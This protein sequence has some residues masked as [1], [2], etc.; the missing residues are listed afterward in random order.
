MKKQFLII[1]L[2]VGLFLVVSGGVAAAAY[3]DFN[4]GTK[5]TITDITVFKNEKL[6]RGTG[7]I[8]IWRGVV[9][10]GDNYQDPSG[11][12]TLGGYFPTLYIQQVSPNAPYG[13]VNDAIVLL[14][15]GGRYVDNNNNPLSSISVIR[16]HGS[17]SEPRE[18]ELRFDNGAYDPDVLPA[19][20][21]LYMQAA[22]YTW[23]SDGI[24]R[25]KPGLGVQMESNQ[26]EVRIKYD[27]GDIAARIAA[28]ASKKASIEFVNASTDTFRDD[29][30][31]VTTASIYR[32]ADSNE[33]RIAVA[34]DYDELQDRM[35]INS[36]GNV[37]IGTST[38]SYPLD[39]VT[40]GE[41]R[42]LNVKSTINTVE[43]LNNFAA[44][45]QMIPADTAL[46]GGIF[47]AFSGNV[48]LH[49]GGTVTKLQ[50][51]VN[52]I[53][54]NSSTISTIDTAVGSKVEL[55]R[56]TGNTAD[57]T[58]T[59]YYGFHSYGN[60]GQGSGN[61]GGTDWRHAYFEDFPD[62]GGTIANVAGLWIDQQTSGTN[63]YGIV[64]NGDGDGADIVFG[65]NQEASIYSA[66]GELWVMDGAGNDTQISPH[67]PKTGEWI[68]YS[69]NVKTGRVLRVNMEELVRD[70]EK[71]TGKKYLIET[72]IESK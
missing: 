68:F 18:S 51:A 32:P 61:I 65:P 67:D 47:T 64:L 7:M 69:K 16:N 14:V 3:I 53:S 60:A 39:V 59:D 62:F 6:F 34:D 1:G 4:D 35:V 41:S 22:I 45:Y 70:M 9:S 71:L 11:Y 63:N 21:Y 49:G 12:D 17:I 44:Y 54:L 8:K 28:E 30:L 26:G 19:D 50:G 25:L 72:F 29:S 58:I 36:K 66:S 20:K 38:P 27:A 42:A 24:L 48:S 31:A 56:T 57:H 23:G 33:L 46:V 37:G 15:E 52:N 43:V 2:I 13:I 5:D 40:T 10:V 55:R